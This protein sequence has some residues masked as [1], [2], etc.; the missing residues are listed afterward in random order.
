MTTHSIKTKQISSSKTPQITDT[1]F[2]NK[3][4]RTSGCDRIVL[5]RRPNETSTVLRMSKHYRQIAR[6]CV[7]VLRR[8]F[9]AQ[10][11]KRGHVG[12]VSFTFPTDVHTSVCAGFLREIGWLDMSRLDGV[13]GKGCI[14]MCVSD[15]LISLLFSGL[16]V[17]FC[18]M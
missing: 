1:T 11:A 12:R 3:Y 5:D 13:L 6:I 14:C 7:C 4:N 8:D 9:N 10:N 15:G 16:I 17:S 18:V 2:E